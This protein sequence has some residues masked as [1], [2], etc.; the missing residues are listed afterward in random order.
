MVALV[1]CVLAALA[2]S[3]LA[4]RVTGDVGAAV[5]EVGSRP[6]GPAA[7]GGGPL[8]A[9]NSGG[10]AGAPP[11]GQ[12]PA[13]SRADG[14]P[15]GVA[16]EASDGNCWEW[17]AFYCGGM[18][19]ARRGS[20]HAIT[21]AWDGVLFAACL[22]HLCSH[23][24]FNSTYAGL[25]ELA[26]H[27]VSSAAAIWN[28]ETK[29]FRDDWNNGHRTR[30]YGRVFPTIAA[31]VYGGKGIGKAAKL[32]KAGV[33]EPHKPRNAGKSAPPRARS[34]AQAAGAAEDAMRERAQ[35]IPWAQRPDLVEKVDHQGASVVYRL[36]LG[37]G[38]YGA[39][40]ADKDGSPTWLKPV[41][42]PVGGPSAREVAFFKLD[43]K[44][45]FGLVPPTIFLDGPRGHG[46]LQ[47]WVTGSSPGELARY[48]V[49]DRERMAVLDY[50]GGNTDRHNE[51][52]KGNFLMRPDGRP[53]AIDHGH[54]FP[55]N[56]VRNIRSD[57][58]LEAMK[59]ENGR[60]SDEVLAEVRAVDP[61]DLARTLRET[62]LSDTAI[63][64]TLKR[65][66]E[67]QVHGMITGEAW[68]GGFSV[69]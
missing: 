7:N 39:Y 23:S 29:P 13:G 45:G 16:R 62:G 21:E 18:D 22:V 56:T 12:D 26:A 15:V 55:D 46:S 59:R 42:F 65:L 35:R 58:V 14:G 31:V 57:F 49:Q 64:W 33:P 3:G 25:R 60:I 44:L 50:V 51:P 4:A 38:M 17:I 8:S 9:V 1:V 27:P 10:S 47:E 36:T 24:N 41:P 34:A 48:T 63:E 37:D 68:P 53:A 43:Q 28:D 11:A 6:C 30:A 2:G 40:K 54:A 19:G 5:C 20:W 69:G 52:G 66:R 61:E 32:G 67:V